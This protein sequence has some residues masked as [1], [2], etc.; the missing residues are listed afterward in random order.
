MDNAK[1]VI[2]KKGAR[3]WSEVLG[4]PL[5]TVRSWR[6]RGIPAHVIADNERLVRA[7]KRAGYRRGVEK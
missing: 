7:L 2:D 4:K 5:S 3:F 1:E 6:D